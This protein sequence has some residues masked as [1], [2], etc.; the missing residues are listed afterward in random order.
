M[1]R[2]IFFDLK[3]QPVCIG[4]GL[5]ALDIVFNGETSMPPRMWT[6]GSCGNVLT[7]LSY[8]G[9]RTIPLIRL[10]HDDASDRIMKDFQ[11]FNVDCNFVELDKKVSTPIIVEQIRNSIDG[12]PTHR[13]FWICPNCGTWLPRYRPVL[14]ANAKRS[15]SQIS[16]VN[17]FYFDRVSPAAFALASQAK[18]AGALVVFEPPSIKDKDLFYKAVKASH[19]VK[20]ANDRIC[21]D[22]TF[23]ASHGPLLVIETLGE[24]GIRYR[25]LNKKRSKRWEKLPSFFLN[26]FRDAAGSGDWC[27][28]GIVYRLGAIGSKGF[29]KLSE[30]KIVEALEFGQ[31]MAALNCGYEGARG[32]I[33]VL[34]IHDFKKAIKRILDSR[35][36][37]EPKKEKVPENVSELFS[38]L[39][40][41]CQKRAEK[42]DGKKT[43]Q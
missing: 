23:N 34:S 22:V 31:A 27:T 12:F 11:K 17:C 28:A 10:G 13:F 18:S 4:T 8:L 14:L 29:E 38:C 43:E 3:P 20:F 9:W 40:P 25:F 33:Y 30:K 21:E 2:K 37:D 35:I 5:V 32:G 19:I 6:G 16:T 15:F 41:G 7:I 36:V 39:C 42:P 24:A 26:E 1:D